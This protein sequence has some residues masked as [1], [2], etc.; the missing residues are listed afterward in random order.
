MQYLK[1]AVVKTVIQLAAACPPKREF[2]A[3]EIRAGMEGR[4]KTDPNLKAYNTFLL[5]LSDEERSELIALLRLGRRYD[6][7]PEDFDQMVER[8]LI[9]KPR[10]LVDEDKKKIPQY[11]RHGMERLA[12][13]QT[14]KR[15]PKAKDDEH[16]R[17]L[18]GR[19]V[20]QTFENTYG[21]ENGWHRLVMM[22]E[23]A[24]FLDNPEHRKLFGL[25]ENKL[26]SEL[27]DIL[28]GNKR[29]SGKFRLGPIRLKD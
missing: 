24:G 6:L 11:L 23:E 5:S 10:D 19:F 12:R 26:E 8:A 7:K 21:R 28:G 3:E 15:V 20:L 4:L 25:P 16:R 9:E 1:K 27:A 13:R 2:T 29:S 14:G 18:I 17:M 22:M